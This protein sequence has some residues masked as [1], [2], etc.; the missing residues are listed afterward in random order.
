MIRDR[1]AI[2]RTRARFPTGSVAS[3][4]DGPNRRKNPPLQIAG[5]RERHRRGRF[6]ISDDPQVRAVLITAEVTASASGMYLGA[7]PSP[8]P[9]GPDSRR[10]HHLRSA[11]AAVGGARRLSRKLWSSKADRIAA[12][13]GARG[14]PGAPTSARPRATFFCSSSLAPRFMCEPFANWGLV[15]PCRPVARYLLPRLVGLTL[16]PRL[17]V[18]ASRGR[19]RC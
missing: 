9:E 7:R 5:M 13:N 10:R 14:R 1:D 16:G 8:K 4:L 19:D 6:P 18:M 11:W 2:F 12:V 17:E 3:V 15:S